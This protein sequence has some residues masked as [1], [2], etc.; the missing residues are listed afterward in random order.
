[1]ALKFQNGEAVRQVVTPISGTVSRF[2][3]NQDT[4]EITYFV[5]W[6]DADGDHERAFSESELEAQV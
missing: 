4:G 3:F 6:T 2:A 1:M 5:S